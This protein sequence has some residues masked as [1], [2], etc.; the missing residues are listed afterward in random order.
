MKYLS[1]VRY[2]LIVVSVIVV[3]LP[4]ITSTGAVQDVDAMLQWTYAMIGIT[5]ASVIILPL[6]NLAKNPK[7]AVRSFVGILIVGVVFAVAYSLADSTPIEAATKTYDNVTELKLS[8]TG[9]YM[10]YVAFS[11][12]IVSIVVTEVYNLFK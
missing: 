10:T 8:D 5:V 2:V 12:A 11:V 4:F 7:A 6:F 3:L 1:I 9:L